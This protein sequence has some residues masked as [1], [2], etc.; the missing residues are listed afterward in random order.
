[1]PKT[2]PKRHPGHHLEYKGLE[3]ALFEDLEIDFTEVLPSRGRTNLA[4]LVWTYSG[5]VKAFP[6]RTEWSREIVKI[7]LQEII[8]R[9]RLSISIHSDNGPAFV[10]ELTQKLSQA[11]GIKWLLHTAYRPQSSGKV[12]RMNHTLKGTLAKFNQEIGLSWLDLLL[13]A[14]LQA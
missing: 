6:T 11:L 5:W 1:M 8:P 14:L 4:V 3:P 7:L 13:L 10:A 9:F 2:T 12:E